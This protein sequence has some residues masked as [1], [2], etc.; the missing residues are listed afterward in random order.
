MESVQD[1]VGNRIRCLRTRLGLSQGELGRPN[2][3]TSYISLVESGKRAAGGELLN[4]VACRLGT[5][6]NF[7]A[8]GVEPEVSSQQRLRLR[9]AQHAL[10]VADLQAAREKFTEL[11][12]AW[13]RE[14]KNEA[15][16]GLAQAE[17]RAGNLSAAASLLQTIEQS[18]RRSEAGTRGMLP[19]LSARCRLLRAA[20]DFAYATEVGTQALEQIGELGLEGTEDHLRLASTLVDCYRI[21]GHLMAAD[22]LA[23]AAIGSAALLQT[24]A[25]QA[26][27]YWNACVVA[28]ARGDLPLA[29]YMSDLALRIGAQDTFV[30]ALVGLLVK[31]A[32]LLLEAEPPRL[33]EADAALARAHATMPCESAALATCQVAMARSRLIRGQLAEAIRIADCAIATAITRSNSIAAED[34]RV[35]RGVALVMAGHVVEGVTSVTEGATRLLE[36]GESLQAAIAWRDLGEAL[37]ISQRT[38]EAVEA[39]RRAADVAGAGASWIRPVSASAATASMRAAS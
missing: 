19:L 4:F 38:D 20:G 31:H 21:R 9:H 8:H 27:A 18:C 34:A 28:E 15:L 14:I 2:Y 11:T 12:A 37:L 26:D 33:D 7:L 1:G 13:S 32:D 29:L 39:L 35:T 25:S 23:V 6:V 24:H 17:E 5:S 22:R 10:S 3:S 30:D 16:W 36:L